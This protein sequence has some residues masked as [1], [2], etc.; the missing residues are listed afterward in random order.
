MLSKLRIGPKLL[1]APGVVLLL[2]IVLSSGAY[3]AMV[4]QN[5]S[6]ESIVEQRAVHIRDVSELVTA[7]HHAHTEIYQLL[8]WIGA[9]FSRARI[10]ALIHDLHRRHIS[11]DRRFSA[12]TKVTPP[13]SAERRFIEQAEAAQALYVK[14]VLEV[15]ELA[16]NDQSISANAMLKAERAF[17]V[18]ALRLSELLNL[19]QE[20][21]ERA[22]QSAAA[23]FQTMS[24]LMPILIAL[25]IILS[26]AIT[27][28]VRRALL[29]EV[30]EIGEAA[31]DLASGNLTVK[32]RVYGKDEISETSRA[33]DT[34]IGNLNNT[35]RIILESARAID[36]ASREIALGNADLSTRTEAQ[37]SSLQ[38]TASSMEELTM[39]VGK[40]ANSALVANQLAENASSVA[41]K[42]GNVVRRLVTTMASI[43]LKSH[44]M[45]EIIGVIDSIANQTNSL[46][47]NAAV[48]AARAGEH[49]RGFAVVATEVRTLAQ[50]TTSAAMEIKDLILQAVAEIEGGTAS[51][52]DAGGSM[53]DIVASVQQVGEMI[54]QISYASA[55]QASGLI[56]VNQAIVQ[57]DQMTQQ[58][59]VLV[60]QA[61][62]AAESLQEQALNLSRA[63][64]SFRLDT[65]I[66]LPPGPPGPADGPGKRSGKHLRLAS[67]RD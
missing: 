58:N 3:F 45:A 28:A 61:A 35:L 42:G 32:K 56:Q 65:G 20:L 24:T 4:R 7:S 38:Q 47:V 63:V 34:S 37:A 53:A 11:I 2:L 55:Q 33:L 15:V 43:K 66:M 50:R 60:E 19:E 51:V 30:R 16:Q 29:Q 48:E 26:L 57:M 12:L 67:T 46:A 40:T 49:G 21:S 5:Q 44:K 1:L 13:G 8:T 6:L 9:S 10:D 23:D 62:A 54:S 59:S 39:T 41:I 52:A 36:I 22:S 14:E 31:L 17:D 18:V 27:V 25:S 64:A